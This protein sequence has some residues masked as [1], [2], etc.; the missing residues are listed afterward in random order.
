MIRKLALMEPFG[1]LVAMTGQ[2]LPY[3]LV[4]A[5]FTFLYAFIPNTRVRWRSALTGGVVGGVIW[6]TVGLIFAAFAEASTSY[7]A[8]Y[9]GFA[10]VLLFIIWLWMSWAILLFGAQVAFF[11]QHPHQIRL[12]RGDFRLSPRLRERAALVIMYLISERH[13][14]GG[15]AWTVDGLVHRLVI[16]AEAVEEILPVLV[17]HGFIAETETDTAADHTYLP[18]RDPGTITVGEVLRAVRA[19]EE[20]GYRAESFRLDLPAVAKITGELD[21]SV[22]RIADLRSFRSLVEHGESP[23]AGLTGSGFA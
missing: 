6:H 9:S 14:S 12:G 23:A 7:A 19:A 5:G 15:P 3:V 4:I 16:P 11:H 8:I 21:R 2:V 1:T 13:M 10:I 22:A 18:T 20:A 17:R